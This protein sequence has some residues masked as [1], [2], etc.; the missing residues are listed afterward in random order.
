MTLLLAIEALNVPNLIIILVHILFVA[1][2]ENHRFI[3]I[4]WS[5]NS[6]RKEALNLP[7]GRH[8]LIPRREGGPCQRK[9]ALKVRVKALWK[10]EE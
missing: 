2:M 9:Q 10:L 4:H 1:W 7:E 6:K 3:G 5:A 8:N